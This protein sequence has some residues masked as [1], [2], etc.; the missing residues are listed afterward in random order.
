MLDTT[1]LA[2]VNVIQIA[3]EPFSQAT[4]YRYSSRGGSVGTTK[5]RDLSVMRLLSIESAAL[6]QQ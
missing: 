3:Q 1:D 5:R 2:L 4:F 6:T